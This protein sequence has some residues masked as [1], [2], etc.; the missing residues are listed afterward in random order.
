[1]HKCVH[2]N[3]T[4]SGPNVNQ[5]VYRV[6]THDERGLLINVVDHDRWCIIGSWTRS[7]MRLTFNPRWCRSPVPSRACDICCCK[8]IP[9]P[10]PISFYI[11]MSDK[12]NTK[13]TILLIL[14]SIFI[15]YLIIQ[16]T[17]HI[18]HFISLVILF[19][20]MSG[21]VCYPKFKCNYPGTTSIYIFYKWGWSGN[22][23]AAAD[24]DNELWLGQ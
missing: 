24:V 14:F 11:D 3:G 6:M 10:T 2:R 16:F 5:D 18:Y 9:R 7:K 21:F 20:L 23:F 12:I 8:L 17:L 15:N 1:M 19:L 4:V 13:K 22:Q